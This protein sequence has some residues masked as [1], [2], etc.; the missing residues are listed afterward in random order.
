MNDN[1]TGEQKRKREQEMLQQD[2]REKME[3]DELPTANIMVAGITGTGKSTLINAVFKSEMAATG[4]GRPVT[5]HLQ[6]YENEGAHVRIWDT[7]GLELDSQ[8]TQESLRDIRQEIA[9]K[10][11]LEDKYDRIHAIW[12]C[13]NSGSNRY[14]G[15]ELEFIKQLHSLGIP[16]IIVL[17]QCSGDEDEIKK[18]EK[19]IREI[20]LQM[21]MT[22]ISIVQVLALP[23]KYRGMSEA[24]QPFGLEELVKVTTDQLPAFI[25]SGF[26]AAQRI[27][28]EQKRI[29]GEKVIYTYVEQAACGRFSIPLVNVLFTDKTIKKMIQELGEL[30]N[31][32]LS[33]E[34]VER[35]IKGTNVDF[36][37]NFNGLINPIYKEYNEKIVKLL[38][39]K[40]NEGMSVEVLKDYDEKNRA[41]KMIAFYGYVFM[42]S[43][44]E[45]WKRFSDEQLKDVD[46]TIR[47]LVDIVNSKLRDNV[48][49]MRR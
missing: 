38:N 20:N 21:G 26:V 10:A 12:Y 49:R 32:V 9:V 16:F 36:A 48:R 45:L 22:D 6:R 28:Q 34:H 47:K 13:I 33:E 3:N 27:S 35:I 11:E 40:K 41:A 7:V 24:V 18:F 17:T 37:N 8:K 1:L 44:E 46:E 2:L 31:T 19:E 5:E 15:A 43:V 23:V 14:Q 25:K 30:Y 39:K 4:S 42:E 29:E